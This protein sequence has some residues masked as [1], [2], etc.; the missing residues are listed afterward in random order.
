MLTKIFYEIDNFCKIFEKEWS[1]KLL[2][3]NTKI[4]STRCQMSLS[5]IMTITIYFHFSGYRTFKHYYQNHVCKNLTKEFKKLLSYNRF[6]EIMQSCLVP[7]IIFLKNFRLG[8]CSG[9]SFVDSTKLVISNNRRIPQH[10]TFKDIANRGKD[11]VGWFYGFK[12]HLLINEKGEIINFSL[13]SGNV[14]DR[15]RGVFKDLTKGIIGKIFGDKGY[16]SSKLKEELLSKGIELITKVKKNMK[17]KFLPILDKILLR[18]R[19]V[20]ESVND[21]LKNT[22]Q[23]EHSRHRS[24]H[25][26]LVNLFSGLVAYSFKPH[27]PS[28]NFLKKDLD[29]LANL[30]SL[31]F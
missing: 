15:N 31:S 7:L 30:P 16:I 27:K 1:K 20:I 9:I 5:E 8:K 29:L 23:I 24:H 11:S 2:S 25:N 13:T 22:C 18:K 12:L 10:K 6:V 17:E 14:N 21:E 19:A 4:A 28:I 3:E 26:F